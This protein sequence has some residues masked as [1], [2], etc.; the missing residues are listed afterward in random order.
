M[1]HLDVNS[2]PDSVR[3]KIEKNKYSFSDYGL[4]TAKMDENS[5][6]LLDKNKNWYYGVKILN[7]DAEGKTLLCLQKKALNGGSYNVQQPVSIYRDVTS[8]FL[9]VSRTKVEHPDCQQPTQ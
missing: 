7:T 4:F 6:Q 1:Q 5:A 2:F 8:E 9:K 3:P